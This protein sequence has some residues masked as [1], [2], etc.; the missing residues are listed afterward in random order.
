MSEPFLLVG[1][2][3][4]DATNQALLPLPVIGTRFSGSVLKAFLP[5]FPLSCLEEI[6]DHVCITYLE[7]RYVRECREGY[8]WDP[9]EFLGQASTLLR[10][11]VIK[12]TARF[13][14]FRQDHVRECLPNLRASLFYYRPVPASA[15]LGLFGIAQGVEFAR[16]RRESLYNDKWEMF[17]QHNP[18]NTF[19]RLVP[20]LRANCIVA[21]K[22]ASAIQ[23]RRLR[24]IA[25]EWSFLWK[26]G[27]D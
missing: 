22:I 2:P 12:A 16:Q 20:A 23:D 19:S 11:L 25:M 21:V 27:V 3:K 13:C 14:Q 7:D 1:A 15:Y 17:R 4:Q 6:V 18:T 8:C 26:P 5:L 24:D 10:S 9:F